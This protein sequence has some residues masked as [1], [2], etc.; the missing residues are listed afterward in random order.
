MSI[1]AFALTL[2]GILGA[3]GAHRS[4]PSPSAGGTQPS[5]GATASVVQQRAEPKAPIELAVTFDDL[6][7]HGPLPAGQTHPVVLDRILETIRKHSLPPVTGFVNGLEVRTPE[8]RAALDRW[9][10]AGNLVGSHTYSHASLREVTLA[11]YLTEPGPPAALSSL[12][13]MPILRTSER[14]RSPRR[15]RPSPSPSCRSRCHD[16]RDRPH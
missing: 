10:A 4:P 7:R 11:S 14:G 3:C 5:P 2:G 16:P 1:R 12:P 15:S 8:D 13:G 9:L 6:P